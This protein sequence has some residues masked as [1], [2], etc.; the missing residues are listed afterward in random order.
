MVIRF[1]VR[2]VAAII[3]VVLLAGII[4]VGLRT[5]DYMHNHNFDFGTA[6]TWAWDDM[7]DT[8]RQEKIENDDVKSF[9]FVNKYIDVIA[10]TAL[11]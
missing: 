9:E 3:I 6:I 5:Y 7:L 1:I 2:L 11:P 10:C 4:A 8:V